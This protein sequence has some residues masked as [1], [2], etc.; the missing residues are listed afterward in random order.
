MLQKQ[1]ADAT[2]NLSAIARKIHPTVEK[3]AKRQIKVGTI[4]V[5][6]HRFQQ[7]GTISPS[8]SPVFSFNDCL[9]QI[10]LTELIFQKTLELLLKLQVANRQ[11]LQKGLFITITQGINEISVITLTK[12]IPTLL[13]DLTFF[14]VQVRIDDLANITFKVPPTYTHTPNIFYTLLGS[15]AAQHINVVEITTTSTELSLLVHKD[16]AQTILSILTR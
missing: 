5:A 7:S 11:I 10:G 3:R 12:Q 1:L 15:L 4:T 14:K 6:L 8:P 9:V 13:K 16:D 2:A